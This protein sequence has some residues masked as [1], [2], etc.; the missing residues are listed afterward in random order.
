MQLSKFEYSIYQNWT[1]EFCHVCKQVGT[2][3]A[4]QATK[5]IVNCPS[6]WSLYLSLPLWV[7]HQSQ[8]H[9]NRETGTAMYYIPTL[10]AEF[11]QHIFKVVGGVFLSFTDDFCDSWFSTLP[12]RIKM[13]T[14]RSDLPS[15]ESTHLGVEATQIMSARETGGPISSILHYVRC[16]CF[17]R[18][19]GLVTFS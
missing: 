7:D 8:H 12:W 14:T 9:S 16:K 3:V 13:V 4:S 10:L 1:K 11:F 2:R 5:L 18:H 17:V 6:G 19:Q 15:K